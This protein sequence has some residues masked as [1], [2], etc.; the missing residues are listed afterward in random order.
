VSNPIV[1]QQLVVHIHG[2]ENTNRW[3]GCWV[4]RQYIV[5]STTL[6]L[7]PALAD[8]AVRLNWKSTPNVSLRIIFVVF[9]LTAGIGGDFQIEE[10]HRAD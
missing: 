4:L 5:A 9:F 3:E 1:L 10:R 6:A 8:T 7:L 2:P